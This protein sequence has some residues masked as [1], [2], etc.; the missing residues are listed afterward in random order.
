MTNARTTLV[1]AHAALAAFR[2]GD[3]SYSLGAELSRLLDL[4]YEGPFKYS[5]DTVDA[6]V[7]SHA[8]VYAEVVTDVEDLLNV[9]LDDAGLPSV[10]VDLA[11]SP[12]EFD[13][14]ACPVYASMDD[15]FDNID[16]YCDI[17]AATPAEQ[18]DYLYR[19]LRSQ[20]V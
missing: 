16:A 15:T 7:E 9:L 1:E 19:E 13:G 20:M 18:A 4:H 3:R 6:L 10:E 14:W 8:I 5:S 12:E 2:K 17:F 11:G